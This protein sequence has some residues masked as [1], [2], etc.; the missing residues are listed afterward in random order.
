M[1]LFAS[2]CESDLTVIEF[3]VLRAG[4][5]IVISAVDESRFAECGLLDEIDADDRNDV[6]E[7]DL[8]DRLKDFSWVDGSTLNN[9]DN[10][11]V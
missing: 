5:K 10:E 11:G 4:E 2:R 9:F 3:Y 6:C 7:M 1:R 8:F